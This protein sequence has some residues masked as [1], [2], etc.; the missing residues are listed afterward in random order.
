MLRY[1]DALLSLA[2]EA[3]MAV[4]DMD[5]ATLGTVSISRASACTLK[6]VG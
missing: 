4:Q 5:A 6:S 1:T 3:S 2:A